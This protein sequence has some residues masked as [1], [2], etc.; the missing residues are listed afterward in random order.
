MDGGKTSGE[1]NTEIVI[2]IVR[3]I[4]IDVRTFSISIADIDKLAIRVATLPLRYSIY[5]S[6]TMC[7][8]GDR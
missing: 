3:L 1:G 2:A 4:R 6:G 7:H 8:C 5:G